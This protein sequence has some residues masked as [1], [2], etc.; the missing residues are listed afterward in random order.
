MAANWDDDAQ[1]G[2]VVYELRDIKTKEFYIG[3]SEDFPKRLH[4]HFVDAWEKKLGRGVCSAL[5]NDG[6]KQFAIVFREEGLVDRAAAKER[7]LW[8][9][10]FHIDRG[11]TV[12]NDDGTTSRPSKQWA[13]GNYF[14][15]MTGAQK[16]VAQVEATPIKPRKSLS[17]LE[18]R[19]AQTLFNAGFRQVDIAR[20]FNVA[21]STVSK[22]LARA[23]RAS[24]RST[25][26]TEIVVE[27]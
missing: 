2:F 11:H 1:D 27:L 26:L 22:T 25:D 3:I 13:R 24:Q 17:Q 19:M 8:W 18:T 7:E 12:L 16:P 21:Q 6:L 23:A 15:G 10:A 20:K 9:I 5:R 14:I 4:Y